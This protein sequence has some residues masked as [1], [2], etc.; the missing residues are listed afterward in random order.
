MHEPL[1]LQNM[2]NRVGII[3]G[4]VVRHVFYYIEWT[5]GY[6]LF[7]SIKKQRCVAFCKFEKL[8]MIDLYKIINLLL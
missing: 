1:V 8:T 5:L 6:T 3:E 2:L 7:I 4:N